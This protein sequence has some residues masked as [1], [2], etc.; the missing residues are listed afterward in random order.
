MLR[1]CRGED[2]EAGPDAG[3]GDHRS[4]VVP[5]LAVVSHRALLPASQEALH[6]ELSEASLLEPEESL[7]PAGSQASAQRH[8]V[9]A[10]ARRQDAVVSHHARQARPEAHPVDAVAR[11]RPMAHRPAVLLRPTAQVRRLELAAEVLPGVQREE[12]PVQAVVSERPSELL[13]VEQAAVAEVPWAQ[14]PVAVE[15]Q[16]WVQPEAAAVV[17]LLSE[18]RVVEAELPS[19]ERAA[20]EAQRAAVPAAE[21]ERL[22]AERV[23]EAVQPSAGQ[24]AV[25]VQPSEVRAELPSAEPSV[26]SDRS[27]RVRLVR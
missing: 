7:Q 2:P 8:L 5:A 12:L 10:D 19:A 1:A 27:A 9:Q 21:E 11:A 17:E 6:P 13:L 23:V 18:V 15:A 22:A 14:Q 4:P 26:R 20:A 16:P 3:R 24:A 25:P